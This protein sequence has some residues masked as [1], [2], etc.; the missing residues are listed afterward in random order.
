MRIERAVLFAAVITAIAAV[1]APAAS[2][3]AF[4]VASVKPA[5]SDTAW[6]YRLNQG[7][8]TVLN[9]FRL[10][11]LILK[12][13]NVP[14]FRLIGTT[15]W[16]DS[17]HF[18]LEAIGDV[19]AGV[20]ET[21]RMIQSLV[22]DRFSL[23]IHHETREASVYALVAGK[24]GTRMSPSHAD[25]CVPYDGSASDPPAGSKLP[26]CSFRSYMH[27]SESGAALMVMEAPGV[28]MSWIA[29]GLGALVRR[30]VNDETGIEGTF[31][32]K[33]EY[34]PDDGVTP[35]ADGGP[36]LFT[37]VQEQLGLRLESRKAL[38]DF[39]VVDRAERP[40]AN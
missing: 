33:I 17:E 23:R 9:G 10:R 19:K 34:A 25:E 38:V 15:G 18:N 14:D 26:L 32:F 8:R 21:L 31:D 3:P 39:I 27:R 5:P 29:R 30:Q 11:D 24:T 20:E 13:W 12:A 7:G 22:L 2:A 36:S 6:G 28:R 4:E 37:A 16:M 35:G 40:S 1:P